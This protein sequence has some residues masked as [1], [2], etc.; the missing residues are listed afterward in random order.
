MY[1]EDFSDFHHSEEVIAAFEACLKSKFKW[2]AKRHDRAKQLLRKELMDA[3]KGR[4]G[5]CRRPIKNETGHCEID[6]ILPKAQSKETKKSTSN[7]R[8]DRRQTRGY[9]EFTFNL[10]NLL[11]TCKKCNT[12]KGSYDCRRDRSLPPASAKVY[13]LD[14]CEFEWVHPYLHKY[15]EHINI[16]GNIVYEAVNCSPN[17][18]AVI[19]E[20]KLDEISAAEVAAREDR[21]KSNAKVTRAI[22]E[23]IGNIEMIGIEVFIDQI[24]TRFTD[25]DRVEIE[26]EVQRV[27]T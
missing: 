9:P 5:Y 13:N 10:W 11:L 26:R 25:V 27:M 21:L 6:H 24:A 18:E 4:C 8:S 16:K 17:G 1:W 19:Q 3:Q 22:C 23:L 14:P 2:D 20:C 12:N 15:S 7:L